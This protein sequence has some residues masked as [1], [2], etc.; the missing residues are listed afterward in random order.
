MAKQPLGCASSA[1]SGYLP[2]SGSACLRLEEL[3]GHISEF[4]S[5]TFRRFQESL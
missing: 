2:A 1:A 5:L 4:C 3:E